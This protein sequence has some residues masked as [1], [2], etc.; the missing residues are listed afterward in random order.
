M[1]VLTYDL[2][3]VGGELTCELVAKPVLPSGLADIVRRALVPTGVEPATPVART[4]PPLPSLEPI[5]GARI[6]LVEDNRVNQQIVTR[7]LRSHGL[8]VEVAADGA[9]ALERV[10][11]GFDGV[12]MDIQMPRMNGYEATRELRRRFDA[13]RLPIIAMSANAM[14]SDRD[15][16]REAGM[17]G[18]VAKPVEFP[19]FFRTLLEL[20]RPPA[21][22][23]SA[24][25]SAG[26]ATEGPDAP[27]RPSRR[28]Q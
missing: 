25:S 26:S 21:D 14:E 23:G 28:P 3:D 27:A 5:R 8:E 2:A 9:E 22:A 24:L 1:V 12:L 13:D 7:V 6:L 16:C 20:I 18:H 4:G 11:E 17:N 10:D 19:S 15:L